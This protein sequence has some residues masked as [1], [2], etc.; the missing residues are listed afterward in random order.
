MNTR[1]CDICQEPT[2]N[3]RYCS[4]K[5]VGLRKYPPGFAKKISDTKLA[6]PARTIAGG[7]KRASKYLYAKP[8]PC[9]ACGTIENINRHHKD[10][11]PKNNNRDNIQFL[12]QLHHQRLHQNWKFRKIIAD[13]E[14]ACELCG[15][16]YMTKRWTDRRFCNQSCAARASKNWL[17]RKNMR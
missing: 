16:R 9:E 3:P 2:G 1:P 7:Y 8:E 6:M 14:R 10:K 15:N 4:M 5:C 13:E 11:D 17:L 12:C